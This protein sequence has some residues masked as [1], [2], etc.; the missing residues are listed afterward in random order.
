MEMAN[1]I[2]LGNRKNN[3]SRK[4]LFL[5]ILKC[6]SDLVLFLFFLLWLKT[7][8]TCKTITSISFVNDLS[9]YRSLIAT[10][11]FHHKTERTE[12]IECF[13]ANWRLASCSIWV[14]DFWHWHTYATNERVC[15]YSPMQKK[16]EEICWSPTYPVPL[17]FGLAHLKLST[18]VIPF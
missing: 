12:M 13:Q 4:V 10:V 14:R 9:N 3:S 2:V 15:M 1:L 8:F 17:A 6:L 5:L 11:N 7:D 18:K 16:F